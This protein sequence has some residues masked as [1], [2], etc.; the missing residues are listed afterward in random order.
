VLYQILVFL[1]HAEAL[2]FS[3]LD[4]VAV[5]LPQRRLVGADG[6]DLV[7]AVPRELLQVAV[8]TLEVV[9]LP[10]LLDDSQGQQFG[11]ELGEGAPPQELLGP[12]HHVVLEELDQRVAQAVLAEDDS[13]GE[14][15]VE[16]GDEGRVLH[17]EVHGFEDGPFGLLVLLLR[18]GLVGVALVAVEVG[19]VLVQLNCLSRHDEGRA[20]PELLAGV[21]L[22]E[23]LV[24][25]QSE[26]HRFLREKKLVA[27][28]GEQQVGLLAD[29]LRL[30]YFG[31]RPPQTIEIVSE[32]EVEGSCVFGR[33]DGLVFVVVEPAFDALEIAGESM[34]A[35]I[36]FS[37]FAHFSIKIIKDNL[38]WSKSEL[39]PIKYICF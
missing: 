2:E 16:E 3:Q 33:L 4:V 31:G 26:R 24:D 20:R 19:H 13:A 10:D 12:H 7:L 17:L 34:L 9:L 23:D 14:V 21:E 39:L 36:E 35:A 38:N 18:E 32:V 29:L 8:P 6:N 28:G 30:D 25:V 27:D 11:V 22:V 37:H 15:E 5:D 1:P